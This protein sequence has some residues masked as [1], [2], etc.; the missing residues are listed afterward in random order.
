M[1]ASSSSSRWSWLH[2]LKLRRRRKKKSKRA[3][4]AS[5]AR[6]S[7][8]SAVPPAAPRQPPA[9]AAPAGGLSPC[10]CYCPNRESYYLNSAD[11]ARQEDRQD[12]LLPCD[13]EVEEEEALDVGV[14]VVHRRADGLDAP[15]A[16]PELKLRPIVTSRRHAAAGKNEA[17]D[18][19][20]TSAAT[21]PSTRARGFH[22]RPTAASRRLRRV[23]SSGGGHDSNNA[24]T[25]VSA[26]APA[27]SSSSVS[28]GRPSRR[29]RRR[30]MWLRESEAVV[31][32]STEP[33]LELVDSMIEML[34]TNGVRR[35]EDL[36]DL[37]ACYLSLNAAEHHR[38]I[39]ALFRRVVLV[40]IH[41]GSQRLLPGQ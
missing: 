24:G 18:S 7:D 29:P 2:K 34:C 9:A 27:S 20:S 32:E 17:S 14:D 33:E 25:P 41:L 16:T 1:P 11:R 36:Q 22:V 28:A 6:P 13:D 40:W 5:T 21:T 30:R 39:V 26:P 12:M 8:A 35:L 15:P 19:S 3:S 23:G 10:C 37:L 31:L 4:P 38:T